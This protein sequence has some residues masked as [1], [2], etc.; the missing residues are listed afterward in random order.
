MQTIDRVLLSA[1]RVG[2]FLMPFVPLV[3]SSSLFFPFIT[4][5]GFAFRIIVEIIFACWLLLALR[6]PEFRPQKSALLFCVA[7]FLGVIFLADLF[8]ENP[9]KAFWSNFE[10]MEGFITLIH[11][12]AYFL[13]ASSVMT[14]KLW[15]RFLAT[16]VGVSAFLGIYGLLQLAGKIVINQGGVRLDGT[17]GNAAYFAGYMLVHIF[18][19]LFLIS[20]HR[21]SFSWKWLYGGAMLLQVVTLYFTATRGAALGLIGGLFLTVLLVG[22]FEKKY[23]RLRIAALSGLLII[24]VLVGGLYLARESSFVKESP[25]L[26]RFAS[27]SLADA[28]PRFMV[29]G[30]ALEGFKERPILGWG[31]EGFNYVFNKYYDPNMWAQEQWFDRTH[32]IFFDWLIAGGLFGLLAYLSLFCALLFYLWRGK[33]SDGGEPFSFTEKS[34]LTGLLAAY[35]VHNFF[36]FDNLI[37]YLLFFSL[38]A[39]MHSRFKQPFPFFEKAKTL[40]SEQALSISGASALIV[41][42]AAVFFLNIRAIGVA[43]NLI[44]GLKQSAKGAAENLEFYKRAFAP[45]TIGTQEVAEQA[46]QAAVLVANT[47]A[48]PS[49]LK[50]EF[51]DFAVLAMEREIKRAPND[52]RLRMFIGGFYNRLGRFSDSLPHLQKARELS[53][54]KQTVAFEL[55]NVYL[56]TG[57]IAEANE[58]LKEA[59]E[60]APEYMGARVAYAV[61]AIY[62]KDLALPDKLF[63]TT[64]SVNVLAD[65]RLVKAYYETGAYQK[66]ISLLKLRLEKNPNDGQTYV[67]L[68]AAYLS[69]GNRTEAIRSLQKAIEL[70]PEFKQQGEFYIGEI[71]AGRTP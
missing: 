20:R 10:R 50:K 39:L 61:S 66:V 68:A 65:E 34:V 36:V 2:V 33:P 27:I 57:K 64:T 47:G 16:S 9:F 69:S 1:T 25:V 5:K 3:I 46:M 71:R 53:P 29:W 12:V 55:S 48:V 45:E 28:G 54:T 31:Q 62:S 52:T 67:S 26:T 41:L 63:A 32:N 58:L 6:K 13:V 35:V 56:S 8:A 42:I 24:I 60:R 18:I 40:L 17:F 7:A 44:S 11:L 70:N 30:M 19:S 21:I 37:S 23:Q 59:F 4:G 14:E 51:V 38:I 15:Y 22:L 49:D 43:R